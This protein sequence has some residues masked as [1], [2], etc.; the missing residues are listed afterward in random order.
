MNKTI[1]PNINKKLWIP[2]AIFFSFLS[3]FFATQL[4]IYLSLF[5]GI[6]LISSFYEN[7]FTVS[8]VVGV[9][10]Y[11]FGALLYQFVKMRNVKENVDYEYIQSRLK[12]LERQLNP[13]FLF[14]AL[15]SIAELIHHDQQKAE[16]AVL[17]LSAFLRNSMN[18]KALIS[19]KEEL[20]N[21]DDYVDLEN[22]RF[23]GRIHLH[24]KIDSSSM[25]VPKFS[26][27]L[28][29]ENAIKHGIRAQKELN[30]TIQTN[31]EQNFITISNDGVPLSKKEFGIGLQNLDQRLKLLFN[32]HLEIVDGEQITYKIKLGE[33]NEN[34]HS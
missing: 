30:I 3:G 8:A 13:H 34:T 19:L 1:L 7:I 16:M 25:E 24:K 6:R 17:K 4:S 12:S 9:L 23:S 14:N 33:K 26:I 5:F 21:V 2:I 15:N 10:T 27:Q 22:I 28:I 31:K 20:K 18:E 32:G 11:M 29:V